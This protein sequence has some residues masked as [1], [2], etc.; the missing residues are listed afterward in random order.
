[1]SREMMVI[2]SLVGIY[3][4]WVILPLLPAILIYRLFPNTVVAVTG[5]L[6]NLTVRAGGAFGAYLIVFL[7]TYQLVDSMKE[8]IGGFE[9]PFWTVTG[10]LKLIDQAGNEVTAANLINKLQIH[11][12]PEPYNNDDGI[13]NLTIIEESDGTF[14]ILKMEIPQWGR[15]V[16]KLTPS[17]VIVDKSHKTMEILEPIVLQKTSDWYAAS[18]PDSHGPSR[19]PSSSP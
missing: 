1:M 6:A 19:Q 3:T 15:S 2:L 16:F 7:A 8:T 11:S 17:K 4:V 18:E 13:I 5:P 9:H 12:D 14:P 10:K